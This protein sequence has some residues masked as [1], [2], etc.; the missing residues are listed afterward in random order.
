M[1]LVEKFDG[2]NVIYTENPSIY[3]LPHTHTT[4]HSQR[5]TH[6]RASTHRLH[7]LASKSV[8]LALATVD[9]DV[10]LHRSVSQQTTPC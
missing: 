4:T 9:A 5:H 8:D 10:I 7:I 1:Y 2:T 6:T 3:I